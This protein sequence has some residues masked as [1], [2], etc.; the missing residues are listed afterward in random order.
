MIKLDYK[1]AFCDYRGGETVLWSPNRPIGSVP[2]FETKLNENLQRKSKLVRTCDTLFEKLRMD[3]HDPPINSVD[4][5][6]FLW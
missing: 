5:T 2:C 6:S 1:L 3:Y 4:K